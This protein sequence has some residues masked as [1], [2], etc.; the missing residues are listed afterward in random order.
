LI[1]CNYGFSFLEDSDARK[2][3][4]RASDNLKED[5]YLIIK[6]VLLDGGQAENLRIK[7]QDRL[8][9]NLKQYK[10]LFRKFYNV[11]DHLFQPS[12]EELSTSFRPEIIFVLQKQ[13]PL[14][15]KFMDN[16]QEDM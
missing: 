5:G 12:S 14:I 8:L 11:M 13:H 4:Q 15:L 7:D 2:F 16:Q 3:L 10:L 6:E 1:W 9:R